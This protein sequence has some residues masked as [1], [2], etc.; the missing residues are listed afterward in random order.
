MLQT[1]TTA[2]LTRPM[3]LKP[4]RTAQITTVSRHRHV[5]IAADRGAT[6][7]LLT[8]TASEYFVSD[9][10]GNGPGHDIVI[11]ADVS[12]TWRVHR[13]HAVSVRYQLSRRDFDARDLR[14]KIHRETVGIF[15]TLLGRDRFGTGDW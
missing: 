7:Q 2:A 11:C 13:Q 15:Y 8:S 14:N 6:G 10:S 3:R 4:A 9:L 5:G 1:E 12:L